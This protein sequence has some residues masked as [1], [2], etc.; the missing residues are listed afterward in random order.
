MCLPSA[1]GGFS[2]QSL[3]SRSAER[4]KPFV[5]Q[6]VAALGDLLE[7]VKPPLSGGFCYFTP[8]ALRAFFIVLLPKISVHILDN[9]NEVFIPL[10]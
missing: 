8:R 4:E 7:G 6:E 5:L 1:N 3:E 2:R 10:K 9:L